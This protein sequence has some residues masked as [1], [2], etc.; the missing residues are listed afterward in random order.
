MKPTALTRPVLLAAVAVLVTTSAA[1]AQYFATPIPPTQNR[2]EPIPAEG[3]VTVNPSVETRMRNQVTVPEGFELT[4]FAGPPVAMYPMCV[5]DSPDGAIYVCVDPNSSLSRI[6]GIG[7]VMRLVDEDGDGTADRYTTFAEMDSPRGIVSDGETVYVMHPPELT[8][9]R[10]TDGDGIADWSR[11]LISGLG[12]GLDFRGADHT[13]NQITL[14][15][16]GWIYVAVGDYGFL[17]AV[18]TDGTEI[19]HRGGAIVRVRPDGT[20]LEIYAT[21][22]RNVYDLSISPF[23]ELFMRDNTNDGDGWNTRLHYVPAGAFLGYPTH[24]RNFADEHFPSLFDYGGG[25]GV[26]SV[27]LQDPAWP[28]EYRSTLITADWTTNRIYRHPLSPAGSIFEVEQH[29]FL[30]MVRPTDVVV[31][32]RSHM[33]VTSMSGGQFNYSS[34]TVGYVFR[35]APVGV[36]TTLPN[37]NSLADAALVDLLVGER[38][39]HRRYAQ[40]EIVRRGARPQIVSALETAMRNGSLAADARVAAMFAYKQ[41]LG[42]SANTLLLSLVND[43]DARIRALALRALAD[44]RDQLDGV[45]TSVFVTA[46]QDR[47]DQVKIQAINGLVRLGAVEAA[48]ALMPLAASPDQGMA[49]LAVNAVVQLGGRDAAFRAFDSGSPAVKSAAIRALGMMHDEATVSGL[50]TRLSSADAA[51]RQLILAGL[52]RLYNRE[53]TWRGDW[54]TT[55]PS[56]I[57]PYYA[58][59]AWQASPRIRSALRQ[60]LLDAQGEDLAS[61]VDLLVRNRVLPQG[62]AELV[63]AAIEAG[64]EVLAAV[65]ALLGLHQIDDHVLERLTAVDIDGAGLGAELLAMLTAQPSHTPAAI[66]ILRGAA[67]DGSLSEELRESIL[68]AIANVPGEAGTRAAAPIFAILNPAGYAPGD[69]PIEDA[70]RRWVGNNRRNQEIPLF[71]ELTESTNAEERVL[72]YAVLL[73][74]IRGNNVPAERRAQVEPVIEAALGNQARARELARAVTIMD[75]MEDY[76][77]RLRA[78][79]ALQD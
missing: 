65:D 40:S 31:D 30:S 10:D 41:V 62:A 39:T 26:G 24:Y 45:P 18:G 32:G 56:F 33:Y 47:D 46:L 15:I 79:G 9:Y 64:G 52:A 14:G 51:S 27:W 74:R 16:D 23:L 36:N 34:D 75:L 3:P 29:E 4:L 19:S 66:P 58:P 57:G 35:V 38:L 37:V 61:L 13:T 69:S 25:S 11:T 2:P 59:S 67:L 49:H 1:A 6:Q 48:D 43:S 54:W 70:W 12:F 50:I 8:A 60:A 77:D 63:T 78:A 22:I 53:G 73:Q 76:G 44:R 68:N 20:N 21:G 42:A 71:I 7:R 5:A 28:A 55:R 17:R 72:A